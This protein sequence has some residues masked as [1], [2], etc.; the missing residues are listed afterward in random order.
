MT[1]LSDQLED[2]PRLLLIPQ[3]MATPSLWVGIYQQ[4][5][6]RDH[7]LP[8]LMWARQDLEPEARCSERVFCEY[9]DS[10]PAVLV[11]SPD[12]REALGVVWFPS[13]VP[14]QAH[15]SICYR[16]GLTPSLTV[17]CTQAAISLAAQAYGWRQVWAQTPW[18]WVV[19]HATR[20]GGELIATLP[21]YV[22]EG[23]K[24]RPIYVM[25][26]YVDHVRDRLRDHVAGLLP[27]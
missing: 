13:A 24:F 18:P 11:A 15:L 9:A 7:L 16:R 23:G 14:H 19:R 5:E 27:R 8:W 2:S 6:T 10:H 22:L 1:P 21:E 26:G 12:E 4:F 20:V 17:M 25:R 3:G